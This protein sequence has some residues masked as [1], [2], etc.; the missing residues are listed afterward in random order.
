LQLVLNLLQAGTKKIT[1]IPFLASLLFF[2]LQDSPSLV[3]TW[4]ANLENDLAGYRIYYGNQSKDY[5]SSISVG[6]VTQYEI[7]DLDAGR[8]YFIA[9]TAIDLAGNESAFSEEVTIAFPTEKD[10]LSLQGQTYNFP[11]PFKIA[12]EATRIRYELGGASRVT[13]EIFD[14]EGRL[15]AV[16]T[17]EKPKAV[18]EHIEDVWDGANLRGE[19][20]ANGVYFCRIK[21]GK[22]ERFI[23]IAVTR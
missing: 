23:K 9:L 18:G 21:A 2:P 12:K 14:L 3:L 19:Y 20:V 8:R 11:N 16:L 10:T 13:I 4:E 7:T 17:E 22:E 1:S 15:V 5:D 6:K